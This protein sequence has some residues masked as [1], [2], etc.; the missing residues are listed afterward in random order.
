MSTY[1]GFLPNSNVFRR[2]PRKTWRFQFRY[3][4]Y[5]YGTL[6]REN[7][8]EEI[9]TNHKVQREHYNLGY[10]CTKCSKFSDIWSDEPSMLTC[11]FAIVGSAWATDDSIQRKFSKD[12]L[13]W[14]NPSERVDL[15]HF[16]IIA[17]T[18]PWFMFQLVFIWEIKWSIPW[19][20][21]P[22]EVWIWIR[23]SF[24]LIFFY[25]CFVRRIT[26]AA[27]RTVT[28]VGDLMQR[29]GNS[30]TGRVLCGRAVERSGGAVCGLHLTRGD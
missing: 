14:M 8:I 9:A 29:T 26:F 16:Q 1:P 13:V 5:E 24:V 30:R 27:M 3:S 21:W 18:Y 4:E 12:P 6:S 20:D 17:D 25:L 23:D 15:V 2:T 19:F 7:E 10:R 28:E 22:G 11:L